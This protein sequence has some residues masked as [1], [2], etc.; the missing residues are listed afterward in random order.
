MNAL[1]TG[2][3]AAAGLAAVGAWHFSA[4]PP[5]LPTYSI[6]VPEA[7]ERLRGMELRGLL[8]GRA[9]TLTERAESGARTLRWDFADKETE[10]AAGTCDISLVAV[11]EAT[12]KAEVDC[13]PPPNPRRPDLAPL[14]AELLTLVMR[15]NAHAALAGREF[16]H[17]A[18][19]R[20]LLDFSVRNRAAFARMKEG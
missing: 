14:G 3:A 9:F 19:G 15:Q 4:P 1:L 10:A 2:T 16:D 11:E 17:R 20:A 6:T 7:E 18:M 12:T 13:A 5:P 8:I